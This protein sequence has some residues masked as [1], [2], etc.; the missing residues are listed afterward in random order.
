MKYLLIFRTDRRKNEPSQ[1]GTHV[2]QLVALVG[3]VGLGSGHGLASDSESIPFSP[4]NLTPPLQ[5]DY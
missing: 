3:L 4:N 1:T 2:I 5:T